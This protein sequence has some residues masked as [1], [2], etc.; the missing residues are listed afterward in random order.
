M[1]LAPHAL[2]RRWRAQARWLAHAWHE[3]YLYTAHSQLARVAIESLRAAER[4]GRHVEIR[5]RRCE[6]EYRRLV[7]ANIGWPMAVARALSVAY[8][9]QG[10]LRHTLLGALA[11]PHPSPPVGDDAKY[12]KRLRLPHISPLLRALLLASSAYAGLAAPRASHL[13]CPPKIQLARDSIARI[14]GRQLSRRRIANAHWRWLTAQIHKVRPPLGLRVHG[15]TA[16][17]QQDAWMAL[18]TSVEQHAASPGPSVPR[19]VRHASSKPR[20]MSPRRTSAFLRGAMRDAHDMAQA[21]STMYWHQARV[22]HG[23]R[24]GTPRQPRGRYARRQWARLLQQ[25]PLMTVPAAEAAGAARADKP[26]ARI[27]DGLRATDAALMRHG[28]PTSASRA[29]SSIQVSLSRHALHGG[30]GPR[31]VTAQA[32]PDEV[33]F[34]HAPSSRRT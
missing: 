2:Y 28:A 29:K 19:R 25:S 16:P 26:L 8:G 24:A 33:A 12:P 5:R 7:W 32:T 10:R 34:L 21:H 23:Q 22:R 30:K 27:A 3:P 20:V 4:T 6:R 9:R 15:A 11:P 13:A 18:Y 1:S 31:R 14:P 17:G